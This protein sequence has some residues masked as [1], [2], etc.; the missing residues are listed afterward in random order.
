MVLKSKKNGGFIDQTEFKT[1]ET[2]IFDTLIMSEDII[3]VLELYINHVRLRL[4]PK[5]N[6]LLLSSNGTQFTSLTTAMTMLV[7]EAIGK[8]IHPTRYRQIVET[9]SSERLTREEQQIISEDQKHSSNVAKIFYKKKQSMVIAIERKKCMDKMTRNSRPE[10]DIMKMRDSINSEF[11]ENVLNS[12]QNFITGEK[13]SAE[14]VREKVNTLGDNSS[15]SSLSLKGPYDPVNLSDSDT[16]LTVTSLFTN[17]NSVQEPKTLSLPRNNISVKKEIAE[18]A[19]KKCFKNVKFSPEEDFNLRVGIEKYGKSWA[20]IIK[21][22]N[23]VFHP[24]RTRDSLRMRA[25]SATFK[26]LI[27]TND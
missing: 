23:L 14:T 1:A 5:C 25:D 12:A 20:N 6:Y 26:R 3:S 2:Y 7:H 10:N 17:A 27:S 11:D 4:D 21:D 13:R 19:A 9:E 22:K 8:H 16:D 15:C 24:S 18:T